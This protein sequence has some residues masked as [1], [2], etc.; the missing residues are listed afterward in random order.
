MSKSVGFPVRVKAM[1]I[2]IGVLFLFFINF[3]SINSYHFEGTTFVVFNI[4]ME[5][6]WELARIF[7]T[8][9]N[10]CFCMEWP[11]IFPN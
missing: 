7:P 9:M 8:P 10:W 3:R 6:I 11:P 4:E 5:T 2:D 1:R